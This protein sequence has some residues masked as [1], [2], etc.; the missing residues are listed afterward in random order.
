MSI[1]IGH[2]GDD[3]GWRGECSYSA[4]APRPLSARGERHRGTNAFD[5]RIHNEARCKCRVPSAGPGSGHVRIYHLQL[6][7]LSVWGCI[8]A[9]H[10]GK[11][12]TAQFSSLHD[13]VSIRKNWP[14]LLLGCAAGLGW[15][16]GRDRRR[17]GDE[18]AAICYSGGVVRNG[19]SRRFR[20]SRACPVWLAPKGSRVDRAP[21]AKIWE[22]RRSR[23]GTTNDHHR[24]GGLRGR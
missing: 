2:G 24:R 1:S 20:C 22:C 17:W 5:G 15:S 8:W 12:G 14:V 18:P 6:T 23:G 4:L 16:V 19:H 21:W 11:D 9:T 3:Q 10:F 13:H 7:E